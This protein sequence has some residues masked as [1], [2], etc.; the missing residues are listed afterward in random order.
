[1]GFT[2]VSIIYL[3]IILFFLYLFARLL[4]AAIRFLEKKSK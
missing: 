4:L 2:S 3:L 1:M